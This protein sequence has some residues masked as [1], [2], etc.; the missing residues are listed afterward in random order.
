MSAAQQAATPVSC[1]GSDDAVEMAGQE[2]QSAAPAEAVQM[3]GQE[4]Q[5]ALPSLRSRLPLELQFLCNPECCPD[6]SNREVQKQGNMRGADFGD[7]MEETQNKLGGTCKQIL[8]KIVYSNPV[9]GIVLS[10][11]LFDIFLTI[12]GFT[13]V[14]QTN[15][16]KEQNDRHSL[17]VTGDWL[18]VIVL[19]LDVLLRWFLEGFSF[20]CGKMN[21]FEL[22]L[23]VGNI[24][25]FALTSIGSE[26]GVPL[27]G[28]RTLRP[29]FRILRIVRSVVRTAGKGQTYLLALRHQVSGDR[30][31]FQQEGFD[32]DLAHITGQII[33]M[34]TPA[35][36]NSAESVL[37]NP[38]LDVARFLNERKGNQYLILNLMEDVTYPTSPFFDRYLHFPIPQDGV[39][40]LLGLL[41]LCTVLDAFLK[42][43]PGHLVAVHSKNGQGRVGLVIIALLLHRGVYQTVVDAVEYFEHH[44]VH[45]EAK[46]GGS[47]QTLDCA[48]QRRF[49]DY[50]QHVCLGRDQRHI[51]VRSVKLK[52]I[53]ISGLPQVSSLELKCWSHPGNSLK[54]KDGTTEDTTKKAS[55]DVGEENDL[56]GGKVAEDKAGLPEDAERTA[57][58]LPAASMMSRVRRILA[59]GA[60]DSQIAGGLPMDGQPILNPASENI[61]LKTQPQL[62]GEL[63]PAPA[64]W[65]VRQTEVSGEIRLEFFRPIVKRKS[66]RSNSAINLRS[67][68]KDGGQETFKGGMVFSCWLHSSYLEMDESQNERKGIPKRFLPQN[69]VVVVLDRFGLDKAADAPTLRSYS[70]SLKVRLEFEVEQRWDALGAAAHLASFEVYSRLSTSD[71]FDLGWLTW[72]SQRVWPSFQNSF[73]TLLMDSVMPSV[74]SSLPGPL[75]GIELEKFELGTAFPSF[76]PLTAC[77]RNQTHGDEFELQ[78]DIGLDLDADVDVLLRAGMVSFAITHLKL[79]GILSIKFKPLLGELP[80]FAA[81]QLFFLNLPELDLKFAKNLE[82]ANVPMARNLIFGAINDA[83]L[84]FM[85]LPNIININ[86]ADPKNDDTVSFLNVSPIGVLRLYVVGARGLSQEGAMFK[87]LPDSYAQLSI[88]SQMSKTATLCKTCDPVWDEAFDFLVYDERQHVSAV[89]AD[90]DFTGSVRVL[91]KLGAISIE[92]LLKTGA[93]GLWHDLEVITPAPNPELSAHPALLLRAGLFDLNAD[94][95]KLESIVG[96]GSGEGA[97]APV[98]PGPSSGEGAASGAQSPTGPI[99]RG[100]SAASVVDGS[101][102]R[103]PVELQG[104]DASFSSLGPCCDPFAQIGESCD[105]VALLVCEVFGGRLPAALGPPSSADLRVSIGR[106]H[107]LRRATE[108]SPD[109]VPGVIADTKKWDVIDKLA[110]HKLNTEQIALALG[111]EVMDVE[112]VVRKRGQNLQC[113]QKITVL[114]RPQ[115]LHGATDISIEV[116]QKDKPVA[117]STMPLK[118]VLSTSRHNEVLSFT[119]L[120]PEASE[121]AEVAHLDIEVRLFALVQQETPEED[122]LDTTL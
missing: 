114:L 55:E 80:V 86:W 51:E 19:T 81:I 4:N 118:K 78:L 85:V 28:L 75:K 105:S 95:R 99:I 61:S 43:D 76:G 103:E 21:V 116:L 110:K 45:P 11:I 36:T 71:P 52:K 42:A 34:S 66:A 56:E 8:R 44:R 117:V 49:L 102:S 57:L 26:S 17:Q 30:V 90:L 18:C 87:R 31:R 104:R 77:S 58:E 91:G 40:S 62:E 100:T 46:I 60:F 22:M 32:L 107:G 98:A 15:A 2:S 5:P 25:E 115:D 6:L 63:G 59:E 13:E 1:G 54:N 3:A 96:S 120:S 111:E 37:R 122:I 9:Q 79:K 67:T 84:G 24:I 64:E 106:S 50:F 14:L 73:K 92:D 113:P 112:R 16:Q 41:R 23:V 101:M 33:A 35:T 89:V 38:H 74:K 10:V 20:L 93:S 27:S 47:T 72:V 29:I 12:L 48:S 121:T 68:K 108:V 7:D 65:E 119:T 97:A 53:H 82:I 83:L 69:K 70:T 109:D 88:G 39:P 94:M